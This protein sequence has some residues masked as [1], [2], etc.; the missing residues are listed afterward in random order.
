MQ[1]LLG[2]FEQARLELPEALASEKCNLEVAY[3]ADAA[4]ASGSRTLCCRRC[5]KRTNCV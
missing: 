5:S 4:E 2:V 3:P 1:E